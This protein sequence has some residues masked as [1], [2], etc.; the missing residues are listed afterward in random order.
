M[1]QSTNTFWIAANI[2]F[3]IKSGSAKEVLMLVN[4]IEDASV[5]SREQSE[6]YYTFVTMRSRNIAWSVESYPPPDIFT[7]GDFKPGQFVIKGVQNV[8]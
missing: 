1:P 2:I 4:K 5:F 8:R 7:T 6:I 3:D